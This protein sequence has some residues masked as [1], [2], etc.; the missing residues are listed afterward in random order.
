MNIQFNIID[1]RYIYK[2]ASKLKYFIVIKFGNS[3]RLFEKPMLVIKLNDKNRQMFNYNFNVKEYL[4]PNKSYTIKKIPKSISTK[5]LMDESD[6]K[7]DNFKDDIK[8]IHDYFIKYYNDEYNKD[9]SNL[10]VKLSYDGLISCGINRYKQKI[11]I[12]LNPELKNKLNHAKMQKHFTKDNKNPNVSLEIYFQYGKYIPKIKTESPKD[13]NIKS[14]LTKSEMKSKKNVS[15]K[16]I[17][18]DET[19]ENLDSEFNAL[20]EESLQE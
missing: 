4:S 11:S 3:K 18:K 7:N 19:N 8:E 20:I 9:I 17:I 2:C 15:K 1:H 16:K 14:N 12:V 13:E 6:L 5:L 10:D